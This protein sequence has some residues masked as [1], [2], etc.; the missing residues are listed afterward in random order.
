MTGHLRA[1]DS[2]TGGARR[3]SFCLPSPGPVRLWA[4][5]QWTGRRTHRLGLE[6]R[7]NCLNRRRSWDKTERRRNIHGGREPGSGLPGGCGCINPRILGYFGGGRCCGWR[8]CCCPSIHPGSRSHSIFFFFPRLLFFPQR[9]PRWHFPFGD[10]P[11][12]S[13]IRA[14]IH[15]SIHPASRLVSHR[16]WTAPGDSIIS[17]SGPTG[18][19]K[20]TQ[21]RLLAEGGDN[22]APLRL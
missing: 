17:R 22:R 20:P 5:N 18:H 12:T 9:A 13:A 3:S 21:A 6:K 19:V 8:S 14:G 2:A 7:A 11:G 4:I 15:P 16:H 10:P 1:G